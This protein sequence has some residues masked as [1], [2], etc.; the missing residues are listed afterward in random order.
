MSERGRCTPPT[1][2]GQE[3]FLD[4]L[5][6]CFTLTTVGVGES[7]QGVAVGREGDVEIVFTQR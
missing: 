7:Q 6:G 2:P 5:L 3:D 4:Q 1:R